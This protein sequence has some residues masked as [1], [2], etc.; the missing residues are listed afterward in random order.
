MRLVI[1][2]HG[3]NG[4]AGLNRYNGRGIYSSIGR[5]HTGLRYDT[6]TAEKEE[7]DADDL[8]KKVG[9]KGIDAV[10]S[11]NINEYGSDKESSIETDSNF[12]EEKQDNDDKESNIDDKEE[13]FNGNEEDAANDVNLKRKLHEETQEDDVKHKYPP[14]LVDF[15]INNNPDDSVIHVPAKLQRLNS[16]ASDSQESFI[17]SIAEPQPNLTNH[18]SSNDEA[19]SKKSINHHVS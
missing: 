18:D 15:L 17:S 2:V 4:G 1:N 5:K 13:D 8:D 10:D 14:S 6:N 11:S 9:G 12:T 19:T 7:T 3:R 16:S